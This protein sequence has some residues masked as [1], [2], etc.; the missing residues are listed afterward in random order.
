MKNLYEYYQT[1]EFLPTYA[2][3]ADEAALDRYA[4]MRERVLRD[5]LALPKRVFQGA[6]ILDY[7]PD[8]GEDALAFARWGGVLTLVEPNA[9]AH[10]AIVDYFKRFRL[11]NALAGLVQ[12]DVLNYRDGERYDFIVAEGFIWTVHPARSWLSAFRRQ[13]RDGGMF[14]VTYYEAF[15]AFIELCLRT[16]QA[17]FRRASGLDAVAAAREL[18]G[19]KWDSIPH[20]RAFESWVFDVLE[21]PF[22]RARNLFAATELLCDF[23][24]EGF[25]LYSSFPAYRD[26]LAIGWHKSV[27]SRDESL[28]RSIAHV[29]RSALSFLCGVKLYLASED[30]AKEVHAAIHRLL[31]DVDALVDGDDARAYRGV[32]DGFA[33][34]SE[35]IEGAALVADEGGRERAKDAIAALARAFAYAAKG[36]ADA[37]A[38]HTRNDASFIAA[39]GVP[40]HL[41]VGRLVE[42]A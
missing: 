6:K 13:L 23:A 35:T 19:P 14:L 21:N 24:A 39:W 5:C 20:T 26:I 10:R 8:T 1:R 36:D 42:T 15:G 34:V 40:N 4:A 2:S 32:A 11:E 28:A 3:L 12:G 38:R 25:D 41:A 16:L 18:Y 37:L 9:A 33:G 17:F 29:D 31:R 22:L 7:G 27:V 30:D